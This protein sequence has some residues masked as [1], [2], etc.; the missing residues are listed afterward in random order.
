[1]ALAWRPV[2]VIEIRDHKLNEL[3]VYA[4]DARSAAV[5]IDA[6]EIAEARWAAPDAPPRPLSVSTAAILEL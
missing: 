5:T 4:A 2:A 6:G 1:M 3:H